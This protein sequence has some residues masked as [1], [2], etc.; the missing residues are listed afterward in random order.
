MMVTHLY[1]HTEHHQIVKKNQGNIVEDLI[2]SWTLFK[3]QY[4][5]AN[6]TGNNTQKFWEVIIF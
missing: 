3:V 1:E 5:S 4:W 6:W 2:W